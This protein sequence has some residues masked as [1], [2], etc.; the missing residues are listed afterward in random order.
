LRLR[1]DATR[2]R[3]RS[4]ITSCPVSPGGADSPS[5]LRALCAACNLASR[6]ALGYARAAVKID[7]RRHDRAAENH[8]AAADRHEQSAAFWLRRGDREW[9]DLELRNAGIEREAAGLE[10]DR[11]LVIRRRRAE[12]G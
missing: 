12:G 10:R 11:A 6:R 8:D 3:A 4:S 2:A 7:P 5:N 9:A 1:R